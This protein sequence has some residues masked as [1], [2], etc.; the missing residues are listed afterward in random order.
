MYNWIQ[1][2]RR[3]SAKLSQYGFVYT[4]LIWS[5]RCTID[6]QLLDLITHSL[7]LLNP[8]RLQTCCHLLLV[9]C[10]AGNPAA[11]N[12]SLNHASIVALSAASQLLVVSFQQWLNDASSAYIKWNIIITNMCYMY[13]SYSGNAGVSR[14]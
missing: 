2:K 5:L 6:E 4:N 12:P 3:E 11:I 10:H 7:S 14:V 13:Y 9:A 8:S 1:D